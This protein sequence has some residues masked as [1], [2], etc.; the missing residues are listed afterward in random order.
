[1]ANLQSGGHEAHRDWSAAGNQGGN[2]QVA[3]VSTAMMGRHCV[4]LIFP[5]TS[6]LRGLLCQPT[7]NLRKSG[8]ALHA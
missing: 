8:L 5:F 2:V 4:S 6:M 3:A 1:M 7:K